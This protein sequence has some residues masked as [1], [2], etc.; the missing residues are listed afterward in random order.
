[1]Q[2]LKW[3][4]FGLFGL[5]IGAYTYLCIREKYDDRPF[6]FEKYRSREEFKKGL[7]E[8]FPLGSD[9]EN[10]LRVLQQ[11]GAKCEVFDYIENPEKQLDSIYQIYCE[12][13][14]GFFSLHPL[15]NY[16]LYID[17]NNARKIITLWTSKTTGMV[18]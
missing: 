1:M 12:Y 17:G 9:A 5:V 7:E 15:E 8:K 13:N 3:F 18:I 16:E 14:S 4:G 10:A 2:L 11:S 6:K